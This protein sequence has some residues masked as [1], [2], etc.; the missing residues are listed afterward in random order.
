VLID[1]TSVP[2][3]PLWR[4]TSTST[5]WNRNRQVSS[6]LYQYYH[7]SISQVITNNFQRNSDFKNKNMPRRNNV[8]LHKIHKQ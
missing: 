2:M 7:S 4:S 6:Q 5:R 3:W 1:I 8:K